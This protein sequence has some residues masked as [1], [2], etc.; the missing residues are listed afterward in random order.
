MQPLRTAAGK[1][2]FVEKLLRWFALVMRPLPWRGNY[3]PYAVWIS[4]IMLQQTR[5]ERGVE[6]FKAWMHRFPDIRSVAEAREEAIL[7]AWEGLGYYS[8]ARNL[9]A[10]AKRIMAESHGIFPRF[11][12]DIRALPGVGEYTAGAIAAIAF[13]DPVPAVDTNVMRVFARVCDI[14]I[15]LSDKAA[16][17]YITETVRSLLS[18]GSP[19]L[20][21]QGLMELG[22]LVCR[23]IPNC[24]QCPVD[25]FCTARRLGVA[26]ARPPKKPKGA[27]VR[28]EMAAG[29]L[30]R[31]G[32]I[33]IRKRRPGGLWGGL[34]EF[35]GGN[36][37]PGKSPEKALVRYLADETGITATIREK[38]AIV[39]HSYTT[40]RVVVHGYL[41]DVAGV[42]LPSF[43]DEERG[44]WVRIAEIDSY[45]FPAGHRKLLERLGWKEGGESASRR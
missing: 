26:S 29:I 8:R 28:L 1:R 15:P 3:E 27:I 16:K 40:N 35:P 2:A 10:A 45:P 13:D 37:G 41:C 44:K 17:A 21:I 22:A 43:R 6:Y 23:G 12:K 36:V 7:A 24:G 20:I 31:K 30:V 19:R 11:F 4:E 32:R 18:S 14:D 39:R 9:H 42:L 5:M 25:A 33:L 34:W 38:I